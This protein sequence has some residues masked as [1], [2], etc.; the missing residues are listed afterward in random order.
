MYLINYLTMSPAALRTIS[1]VDHDIY[2]HLQR[3]FVR[4]IGDDQV[5]TMRYE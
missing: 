3:Q 5:H 1:R 4:H 2:S